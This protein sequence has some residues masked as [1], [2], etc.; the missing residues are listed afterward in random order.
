[1]SLH[2]ITTFDTADYAAWR[3]VFDTEL[4]GLRHA[5]LHPVKVLHETENANRVWILFEVQDRHRAEC[6]IDGDPI[7]GD[8]RAGV[9]NQV[10]TF[11]ETA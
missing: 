7:A 3:E 10:H 9:A 1:M 4:S 6:W 5:G 2:M 8:E 11:L